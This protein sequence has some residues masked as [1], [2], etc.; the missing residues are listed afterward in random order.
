M[1]LPPET[2]KNSCILLFSSN[3]LLK[4][5]LKQRNVEEGDRALKPGGPGFETQN[6][7]LLGI[8]SQVT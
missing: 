2:R 1:L 5:I 3:I 8:L 7:H 4:E 6:S